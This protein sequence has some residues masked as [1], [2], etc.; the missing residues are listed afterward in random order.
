MYRFL[1]FI[2]VLLSLQLPG[3]AQEPQAEP[4]IS[5]ESDTVSDAEIE[6]RLQDIF[7]EIESL[8]SVEIDVTS[9]VVTLSGITAN[10][11]AAARAETLAE[12]VTGVVA[13]ENEIERDLTISRRVTPAFDAVQ[14]RLNAFIRHLPLYGLALAVFAA[15]FMAG[16]LLSRLNWFWR[17]LAPNRFVAELLSTSITFVF[18]IFAVIAALTLLDATALLSTLLG[19]A[20]VLG[21]AIGFA[22]KDTIENYVASIM[23]SIRQP[24]QPNDHVVINDQEGRVIRL[25]SRATVLMTLDGNHLRIPNSAV[26]KGNILN[27]SRNPERRFTFLLGIDPEQDALGALALGKARLEA[28]EFVLTDPGPV[29]IIDEI[30]ESTTNLFYAAWIDQRKNDFGKSRSAAIA[31]VKDELEANGFSL[32]DPSY[33]ISIKGGAALPTQ[34]VSAIVQETDDTSAPDEHPHPRPAP[35]AAPDTSPDTSIEKRVEE[36]RREQGET[37]LLTEGG[38]SEI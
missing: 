20:G 35:E 8:E 23:L 19:A 5:V 26:F 32:P 10:A 22:V 14:T 6:T 31:A 18:F 12:R 37:D 13:V 7:Q 11:D 28:L 4:A 24:F 25:T 34:P 3:L 17:T 36:E 33:R 38:Q 2:A 21:L 1:I 30:G 9:G 16:W 27:Y 15:I 29:T